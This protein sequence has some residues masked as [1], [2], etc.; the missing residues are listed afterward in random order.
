[1][2]LLWDKKDES[3]IELN[4]PKSQYTSGKEQGKSNGSGSPVANIYCD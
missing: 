2:S 4:D 3:V 1:M